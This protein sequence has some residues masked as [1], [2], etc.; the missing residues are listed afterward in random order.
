MTTSWTD[1]SSK[2]ARAF[3]QA[4]NES[5]THSRWRYIAEKGGT[6]SGKTFSTVKVLIIL[7]SLG[8]ERHYIDIVSESMPHLKKGALKDFEE[9]IDDSTLKEGVDYNYNRTDHI[10]TFFRSHSVIRFFGVDEWGKVKGSSREI[11]FI[12]EANRIPWETYRQLAVRTTK[13]I[14]IDWNPD[15]PFWFEKKGIEAKENTVILHSTYLDNPYLTKEQIAEIESNKSDELWWK[16]YGLG[17]TGQAK[18][19]IIKDYDT[20]SSIPAGATFL[21]RGLDF[22]FTNDPTAIV[23]VWK[24][25]GELY[26][27]LIQYEHGMDNQSI[28]NITKGRRGETI[29]DSAEPKSIA[30][31]RKFGGGV[32]IGVDKGGWTIKSSLQLLTKYKIHI[33]MH[34]QKDNPLLEEVEQYKW[35][36]DKATGQSLN[37]PID[38]FNHAIDAARYVMMNTE[39]KPKAAGMKHINF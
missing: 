18:G 23:E 22:G 11:L 12:N 10:V 38:K 34:G 33:V 6:R 13:V 26:L 39:G 27:D 14:I 5:I 30:E 1:I 29:A 3:T 28:A 21:G 35:K 7:A 32:V 31:I 2:V 24:A 19:L 8:T 4:L 25:H 20:V 36:E 17:E 37:E 15:A 16:V 9:I